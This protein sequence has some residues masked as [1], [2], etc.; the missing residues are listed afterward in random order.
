MDRI[1]KSDQLLPIIAENVTKY[2]KKRGLTQ[3]ELSFRSDVD[4]TFIGYIENGKR[5]VSI[6][7]LCSIATALEVNLVDLIRKQSDSQNL[8]L[9]FS[10]IEVL[11][12][13]FPSLRMYQQLAN[14]HGIKDIFQD[15][16]GKLLQVLL[17]TGLDDSPGRTGN[18]ALDRLGREYELKTVN[19]ESAQINPKTGKRVKKYNGFTT[20]HHLTIPLIEKYQSVTWIFATYKGIEI[21]TIYRV[22]PSDLEVY[23]SKWINELSNGA[24]K[25]L[26][27]PKISISHVR[28]YG[29]V[30]FENDGSGSL[31]RIDLEL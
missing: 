26:N 6:E 12:M 8:E 15:N 19:T 2:R 16:G 14:Q 7:K 11:N 28:K 27:N 30:I 31:S 18:D 22:A 23:F 21:D 4:R 1:N 10:A 25:H 5:N 24:K 9:S 17:I 3:E 20:N 29:Q 13:L